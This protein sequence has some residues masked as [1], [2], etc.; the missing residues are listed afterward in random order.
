MLLSTICCYLKNDSII[1]SS[2]FSS[3]LTNV[4][5]RKVCYKVINVKQLVCH[6]YKSCPSNRTI[7]YSCFQY[8]RCEWNI[9]VTLKK[10]QTIRKKKDFFSHRFLKLSSRHRASNRLIMMKV[11]FLWQKVNAVYLAV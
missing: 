2:N 4:I 5:I 6:G 3:N 11:P 9:L 1:A 7:F 8:I 10:S